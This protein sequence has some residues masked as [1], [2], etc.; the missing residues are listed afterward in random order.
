MVLIS[1]FRVPVQIHTRSANAKWLE[2]IAH[3]NP[4]WLHPGDAERLGGVRTGELVRV[5]TEIGHFVVKAWVT[6]GI[7]PGVVAC[8][9]HMGRWKPLGQEGGQRQ[10]MATVSLRRDGSDWL[11]RRAADAAPFASSDPDTS[12]IWWSDVGVHQNL[13]F[14]VHPDPVSGM[15]CWHQAVRVCRAGPGDAYGDI[16]VDTARS[17]AVYKRWLAQARC[18]GDS[19]PD[20]TR[21]PHWLLRPLKPSR[22]AYRLPRVRVR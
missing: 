2:E 12:R 10:A 20:G 21:R 22:D 8:S 15:H 13:T 4:L 18:A 7:R 17:R 3:T 1:T 9:H 16:A 14:P 19:S 6:E 5:E 11:L